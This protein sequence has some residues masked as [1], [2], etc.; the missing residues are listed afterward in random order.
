MATIAL[1]FTQLD[2]YTVLWE[3][4]PAS[5]TGQGLFLPGHV[6]H[7]SIQALGT[8]GGDVTMQG[9]NDKGLTWFTLKDE[10][11]TDIVFSAAGAASVDALPQ[12]I[13]PS[14]GGGVSDVDVYAVLR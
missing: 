12:L 4:I 9:S 8:F 7:V 13:R 2:P 14:S 10:G 1:Q 11:G 3:T 5:S 6:H